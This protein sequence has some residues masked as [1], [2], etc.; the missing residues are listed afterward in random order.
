M[1][2]YNPGAVDGKFGTKTKNAVVAFQT[3]AGLD[4]DGVV[5]RKTW[6]ALDIAEAQAPMA[7]A[8]PVTYTVRAEGV[9]WEQY[10]RILE[11]CPLAEAEVER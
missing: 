11:I 4:P 8:E 3:D 6:A 5:G 7:P 2:G 10:K 1:C 9:T